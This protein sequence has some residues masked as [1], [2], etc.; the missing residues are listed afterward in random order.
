MVEQEPGHS[1]GLHTDTCI[2][3]NLKARDGYRHLALKA[4]GTKLLKTAV[5]ISSDIISSVLGI[6]EMISNLF[7]LH[8]TPCTF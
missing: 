6:G 7:K 3:N 8:Y 5:F 2:H 4:L 1:A